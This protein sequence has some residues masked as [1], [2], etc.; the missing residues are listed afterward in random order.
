MA[1]N[2]YTSPT[3][4]TNLRGHIGI[5]MYIRSCKIVSRPYLIIALTTVTKPHVNNL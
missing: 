1:G 4:K 3:P 2:F 5:T